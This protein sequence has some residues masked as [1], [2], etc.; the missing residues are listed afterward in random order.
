VTAMAATETEQGLTNRALMIAMPFGGVLDVSRRFIDARRPLEL[1]PEMREEMI[2]PYMPELPIA[3]EDL[4]NYNQSVSR[5]HGIKTAPSGLESTSLVFIYGLDLYYT[6][7]TPSGTFDILK[8]DFD[9][10]LISLVM[11]ALVVAS[12]AGKRVWRYQN[13]K[14]A[15]S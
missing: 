2:I 6:R 14:Q 8:D 11:I 7:A 12:F 4:I 9:Y 1:T 5:I 10:L 15:W 3:T 13:L